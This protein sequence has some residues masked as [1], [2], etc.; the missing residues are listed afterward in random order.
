MKKITLFFLISVVLFSCGSSETSL[1]S[2]YKS[3][4]AYYNYIR[5]Q[6]PKSYKK[7]KSEYQKVLTRQNGTRKTVPPGI[8]AEYG[9]MLCKEGKMEEGKQYL[10]EEMNLYPESSTFISNILK[11]MEK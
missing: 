11:Q 10:N 9:Y 3:D 7:L 8:N 1:Y 6:N 2:W 4:K 5:K